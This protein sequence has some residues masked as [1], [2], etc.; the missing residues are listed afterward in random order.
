[1]KLITLMMII[2]SFA[3]AGELT[4]TI[5]NVRNN[6][7][8]IRIAL[9]DQATGFPKDYTTSIEQ[10]SVLAGN[11]VQYTFKNLK[12]ARYAVAVFHDANN[13]EDLNT[14]RLGIPQEG[15]GFT[16]NPRIIFGPP[17]YRKCNVL[18]KENQKVEKTIF[19]KHL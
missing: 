19:L 18:V 6:N 3:F 7:G 15:F 2:S 13:D 9:W 12:T 4:L 17:T 10:V 1:M 14:N 11:E 16:N 8:S 5:K